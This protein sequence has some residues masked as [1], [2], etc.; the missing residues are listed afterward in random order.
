MTVSNPDFETIANSAA[1]D[2]VD[3]AEEIFRRCG[4][5]DDFCFQSE[6]MGSLVFGGLNRL[7]WNA[8]NGWRISNSHCSPTFISV[9]SH[10]K[11]E[12]GS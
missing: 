6:S 1:V 9:W 4:S 8:R 2:I 3:T 5:P 7:L 12:Y 10:I 11:H